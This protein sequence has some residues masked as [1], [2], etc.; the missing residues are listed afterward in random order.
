MYD[1]ILVQRLNNELTRKSKTAPTVNATADTSGL[2]MLGKDIAC[3]P[4][5]QEFVNAGCTSYRGRA[6][7]AGTPV[8]LGK[9]QEL[10]S[11]GTTGCCGWAPPAW[12]PKDPVKIQELISAGLWHPKML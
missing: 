1:V 2:R 8:D 11:A 7:P 5:N 4:A 12:T 10:I 3:I 6:L 9:D